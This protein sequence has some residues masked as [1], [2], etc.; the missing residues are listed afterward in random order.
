MTASTILSAI[1]PQFDSDSNRSV[2]L[3]LATQRTSRDC[4][5]VNYELAI[6]LRAAH[7]LTLSK[8]AINSGGATGGVKSMREGDLAISYGGAS[9][10]KGNQDLNQTSYGV[11]L[12]G[13]INENIVGINITGLSIGCQGVT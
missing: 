4:F 1:A 7:T 12:Q 9:S 11:Q 13:L 6:A 3:N 10:I 5:G 8:N 2:H